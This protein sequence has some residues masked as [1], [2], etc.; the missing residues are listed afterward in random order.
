MFGVWLNLSI[1]LEEIYCQ[2]YFCPCRWIFKELNFRFFSLVRFFYCAFSMSERV[3]SWF[4]Q[5]ETGVPTW[6][7]TEWLF[8][9]LRFV[10]ISYF[11]YINI[12]IGHLLIFSSV[13]ST[14]RFLI[15]ETL[16]RN[17][18]IGESDIGLRSFSN[19]FLASRFPIPCISDIEN[20][21]YRFIV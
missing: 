3:N 18:K 12:M 5:L 13:Q 7:L 6:I 2:D 1:Y 20:Q 4:W 16:N 21:E 14:M 8:P 17:R 11:W 15:S 9:D 10:Y 19:N